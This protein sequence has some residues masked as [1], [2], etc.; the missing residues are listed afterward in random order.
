M[1]QR[2]VNLVAPATPN[3]LR[4]SEVDITW[5]RADHPKHVPCPG[6][7]AL[8]V[9]P[10][11]GRYRLSKVLMDGG[12]GINL[13]YADTLTRMK[14]P[15]NN[16][17]PT[18]TTFH[19]IIPGRPA[20][21][22]GRISLEVTFGDST[23][24]RVETLEFEVVNF[25]SAYHAIL[26][27][28][29]YAKFMARPCYVYLQLKLPGPNGVIT[30]YYNF[31]SSIRCED[32]LAVMSEAFGAREEMES[33]KQLA[34]GEAAH[35][36]KKQATEGAFQPAKDTKEVLVHPTD[37]EKTAVISTSLAGQ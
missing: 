11:V 15:T 36:A 37:Q 32:D 26:G 23:N 25:Q 22:L 5:T 27:R 6:H 9:D 18:E 14:I 13:I 19:G 21:P 12:S 3:W 16:L 4:W 1:R 2:E 33:L 34:D 35:P 17:Q 28:P 30:V 29:A 10:Q 8:V 31:Q 20:R 7:F 24:F